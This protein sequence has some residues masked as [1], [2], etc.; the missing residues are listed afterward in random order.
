MEGKKV[1]I[2]IH[3][4]ENVDWPRA[5]IDFY[6]RFDR[7]LNNYF[8]CDVVNYTKEGVCRGEI[9][10]KSSSP[11]I[12]DVECVIENLKTGEFCIYS[13][14][15]NY[16]HYVCHLAMDDKCQSVILS[17][18]NYNN[19]YYWL[20]RERKMVDMNKIKPWVYMLSQPF[21]PNKYR[22]IRKSSELNDKIFFMGSGIGQGRIAIQEIKNMG[23]LQ[24]HET[25]PFHEYLEN[26]CK[27][28]IAASYYQNL[29]RYLTPFDYSGEFCYR[30]MEYISI[31][32]PFIRIEFKDSMYNDLI[33]N[34]HYI[35]IPLDV[36]HQTYAKEGDKGVAKLFINTYNEVKDDNDF[37]NF[38]SKNQINWYNEN[39]ASPNCEKLT[40][41]LLELE[42]WL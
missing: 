39:L 22:K 16:N 11:V 24:N 21:D 40:F 37:L 13:F 9:N 20:K 19:R 35:S 41:K 15:E 6:H 8:D 38:I 28:K 36:A 23:Y 42:K 17:H 29:D 5:Y 2:K 18:F 32:V 7:F 12:S 27:T 10:L 31:G 26:C 25:Y 33:P 34:Y 1:K 3:R 30:D 4:Y 14:C